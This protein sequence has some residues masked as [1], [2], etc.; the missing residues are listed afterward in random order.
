MN[1][2][3]D[4][5]KYQLRTDL[6]IDEVEEKESLKGVKYKVKNIVTI[7][8]NYYMRFIL[9]RDSKVLYSPIDFRYRL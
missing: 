3:V 9:I 4:L 6:A 8:E 2:E 7:Y 1:K 5:E